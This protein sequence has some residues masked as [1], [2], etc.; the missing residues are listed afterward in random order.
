MSSRYLF[1]N[2]TA[3]VAV[4]VV[5]GEERAALP[6]RAVSILYRGR[7]AYS[8]QLASVGEQRISC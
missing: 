2:T 3:I 5:A 4:V 8:E 6:P 7:L 1:S